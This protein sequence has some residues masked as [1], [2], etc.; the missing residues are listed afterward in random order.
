MRAGK[1]VWLQVALLLGVLW[2]V[3]ITTRSVWKPDEPREYAL[4]V[5]MLTQDQQSVPMLAGRAFAEKPPLTYWV[6]SGAMRIFGTGP[7]IARLPNL[8]YG[9]I[10][11]LC[12]AALAASLAR[13]AGYAGSAATAGLVALVVSGTAWLNYLHTIW[14]ATDA[15]LL[16]ASAVAMLGAWLG[17]SA[18]S[19]RARWLGYGLFH[20]GLTAAFL[21]KNLLG[22]LAPLMALGLFLAWEWRW[23]ELLRMQLWL[24]LLLPTIAIGLWL[25]AVSA[26]PDGPHLLHVFLWDNSVGR[27]LPVESAGNYRTGHQ[28]SPGKLVT[29]VALGLLP[30]LFA[31]LA[32][33]R[34]A[35]RRSVGGSR[36]EATAARFL[37][38][39]SLPLI[40][41]LSFSSTVRDVYALPSMVALG[42]MIGVWCAH[43]GPAASQGQIVMHLTRA[44][45]W[46]LG[47]LAWALALVIPW[48]DGRAL[49]GRLALGAVGS[50][51]LLWAAD[52]LATQ[53]PLFRGLAV[54]ASGL[55]AAFWLASPTIEAAQDLRP[56]AVHAAQ[57]AQDH[58][59]LLS[60]RD[61]TMAAALDYA[62]HVD[63]QMT[64]DLELAWHAQPRALALVES[65]SDP[66]ST[67]MRSRL[68]SVWPWLAAKIRRTE[69]PLPQQLQAAGWMSI[70][71]LPIPGGRHYQL[72]APP[73]AAGAAP[74]RA[75]N[76]SSS[77]PQ[78][79][80]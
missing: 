46:L 69:E 32:A 10:T 2:V 63:G 26:Q 79:G 42:A 78:P 20:L 44:L 80:K 67:A 59:L 25:W 37:L 6:A 48:L 45:L 23:R 49:A 62:T 60:T 51:G 38:C 47:L 21:A 58:P 34:L 64:A 8:V 14:L 56:T 61:E 66:L 41:L 15:P 7:V 70:A 72:F 73:S 9:I 4:S 27:F 29:E 24:G 68:E 16:A 54:F 28:N 71:D 13:H 65:G 36:D 30:W 43:D 18:R 5:N 40:A 31:A 77:G 3:G 76:Q 55:C 57:I 50:L 35:L 12:T 33:L 17:P 11:A 19:V 22:V 1:A 52:R 53:I 75:D 74:S 39:A